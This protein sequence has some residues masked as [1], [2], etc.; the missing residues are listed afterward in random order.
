MDE[1]LE[2][3]YQR[4][5]QRILAR[6]RKNPE[7]SLVQLFGSAQRKQLTEH[8]DVDLYVLT[9]QRLFWRESEVVEGIEV[10]MVICPPHVLHKRLTVGDP[11][12][13]Q[14]FATGETLFDRDRKAAELTALARKRY[15]EGPAAMKP[16]Q[17]IFQRAMLTRIAQKLERLPPDAPEA[18]FLA[19][20]GI[21]RA[22]ALFYQR[23]RLWSR[24]LQHCIHDMRERDPGTAELL[25]RY[26]QE[27]QSVALAIAFLDAVIG[28]MGGRLI[29]YES[30]KTPC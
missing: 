26:L 11:L 20:D 4:V 17:A 5:V 2:E 3:R 1:L 23:H 28:P 10:E 9:T 16:E 14:A 13:L 22:V 6:L 24:G 8:S 27:G 19:G 25:V 18:R 21:Q 7:M 12:A 30:E 15:Q 29:A